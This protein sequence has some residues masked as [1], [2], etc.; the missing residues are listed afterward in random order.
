LSVRLEGL[1]RSVGSEGMLDGA[2]RV[3]FGERGVSVD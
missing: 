2:S 3:G 1:W